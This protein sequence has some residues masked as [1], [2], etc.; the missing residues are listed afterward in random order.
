M[1]KFPRVSELYPHMLHGPVLIDDRIG[2]LL[3]KQEGI[4][5][6]ELAAEFSWEKLG[7]EDIYLNLSNFL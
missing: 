3:E 6:L 7:K 2:S 5:A 1:K 4:S